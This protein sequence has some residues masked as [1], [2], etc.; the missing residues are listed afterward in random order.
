MPYIPNTDQERLEMLG[1]MGAKNIQEL[2]TNIPEAIQ[3]NR[4]L[5]IEG[6]LTEQDLDRQLKEKGSWNRSAADGSC[7]LGGGT[8]D[9]SWPSIVDQLSGRS[10]FLTAYTPYQPECSQGTLQSIFE[11]Q[12]MIAELCGMDVANASMYDG[13]SSCA[14]ALLLATSTTRRKRVV[15]SAGLHPDSRATIQTYLKYQNIEIVEAPLRD[16]VTDWN[17]FVNPETAAVLVQQ[18]NFLGNVESLDPVAASCQETGA[19]AIASVNPIALGLLRSPGAAGFDIVVGEGQPLGVPMSYGG[20][21][22]GFFATRQKFVRKI[23]GRLVGASVDQ[24]GRTAYTLTFQTREQHIRREKATSNICTNNALMALRGCIHLAA[25][26]PQGLEEIA[27]VSRQRALQLAE[28]LCAVDGLEL[29]YPNRPFF[30]EVAFRA[31]GGAPAVAQ[32]KTALSQAGI[33]AVLPMSKWYEGMEGIFTLACTERTR[34]EDIKRL[35]AQ[36]RNTFRMEIS[37]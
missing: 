37:L 19:L 5:E 17:G 10:E 31:A 3:L 1:D 24:D 13:A 30:N 12:S 15:V 8:W 32:F 14:E 18:P 7:F 35:C 21:H 34:P 22:F 33:Q 9:H 6:G 20:P 28:E 29:A 36:A 27:C 4:P 23:P 2:F 11:F 16:G 25:L 26:G